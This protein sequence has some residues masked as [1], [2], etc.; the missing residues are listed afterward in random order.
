MG[1]LYGICMLYLSKTR[2]LK[3]KICYVLKLVLVARRKPDQSLTGKGQS[4]EGTGQMSRASYM[5]VGPSSQVLEGSAEVNGRSE[6]GKKA[7]EGFLEELGLC[8]ALHQT[9]RK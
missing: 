6:G 7:Q 4:T 3:K 1:D 9:I 8:L 5:L 2:M